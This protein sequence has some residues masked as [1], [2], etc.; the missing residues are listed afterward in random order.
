[1]VDGFECQ[2]CPKLHLTILFLTGTFGAFIGYLAYKIDKIQQGNLPNS[3]DVYLKITLT[4]F[5]VNSI[6]LS[7]AFNWEAVMDDMYEVQGSVTS[8]GT[9]YIELA[10]LTGSDTGNITPHSSH[11]PP[12]MCSSVVERRC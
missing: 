3:Q 5:Q 11:L 9:A 12:H 4:T 6:A 1:M 2:Q 7:F 8:L 10:C